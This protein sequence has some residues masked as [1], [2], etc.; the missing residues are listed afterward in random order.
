MAAR[1]LVGYLA[2]RRGRKEEGELL[3]RLYWEEGILDI[4]FIL[5]G[6]KGNPFWPT[7]ILGC[8]G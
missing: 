6:Y 2:Y 7:T 8:Q 4:R 5:I 1:L 3:G